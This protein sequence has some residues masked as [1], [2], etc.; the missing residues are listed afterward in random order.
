MYKRLK[1]MRYDAGFK[2][3][4]V[5]FAK[6]T[7]NSAAAKKFSVN[8]KQ[9]REWRKAEDTLREMPKTKCANRGKTCQWPE[10]EEKVLE[11]VNHQ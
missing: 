4:V 5:D 6:G 3:K 11:W 8:E 7:N 10:L 1:R 9:V 2:L